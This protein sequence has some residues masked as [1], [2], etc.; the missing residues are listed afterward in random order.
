MKRKGLFIVSMII[1]IIAL[2][3][4]AV[5]WFVVPFPDW[6]VRSIGIIMLVDIAIV[7][8]SL[9]SFSKNNKQ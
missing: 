5:N 7:V 3:S 6:I 1:M 2:G 4:M 8:Y 9:V